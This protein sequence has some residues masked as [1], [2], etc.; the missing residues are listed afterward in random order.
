[1]YLNSTAPLILSSSLHPVPT[2][3][4]SFCYKPPPVPVFPSS[5]LDPLT[6]PPADIYKWQYLKPG[7]TY[8]R[9]LVILFF[10][11]FYFL[12]VTTSYTAL[13]LELEVEGHVKLLHCTESF[14]RLM[15]L[16]AQVVL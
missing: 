3:P 11:L 5:F 13:D 7:S 2:F 6:L 15:V 9:G 16:G 4:P 8:E 14:P 10:I 12:P 1:M